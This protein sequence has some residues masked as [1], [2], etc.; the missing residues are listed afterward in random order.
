MS[1]PASWGGL[2]ECRPR[3]QVRAGP[4]SRFERAMRKEGITLAWVTAPLFHRMALEHPAAFASLNTLVSGGDVVS[5]T[6][7]ARVREACP[8][9][10]VVNG[11][12]PTENTTFTAT[13]PTPDA[14]DSPL[15]IGRPMPGTTVRICDERRRP[16]PTGTVGELC[17]GGVG[18]ARG[19]LADPALTARKFFTL[20][21][22]RHYRTG[23]LVHA[24]DDGLLHFHGRQDDQVKVRG[25]L[26]EPAEVNAALL[27]LPGVVEPYTRAAGEP[28]KERSLAAYV[29]APHE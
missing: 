9:L 2:I 8:D 18:L 14:I 12:G 4:S 16:V 1:H 19:H 25:H 15:P 21:G 27:A 24:D 5:P 22:L 20:D 13:Y 17:V 3:K 26:V 10:T 6:H 11:Y 23:D 28:G 29:V 7:V